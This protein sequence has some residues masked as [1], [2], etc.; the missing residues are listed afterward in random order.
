[1]QT[2]E[3]HVGFGLKTRGHQRGQ[4]AIGGAAA[5]RIEQRRLAYASFATDDERTAL[6]VGSPEQVLNEDKLMLAAHQRWR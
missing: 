6:I 3:R 2:G 1:V 4:T 5:G